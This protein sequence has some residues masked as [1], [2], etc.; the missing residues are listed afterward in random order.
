VPSKVDSYGPG[1]GGADDNQPF[2]ECLSLE[3]A[4][5]RTPHLTLLMFAQ[6][7]EL[8]EISLAP[9][10]KEIPGRAFL[11]CVKLAK[12]NPDERRDINLP[13]GLET[14]RI[15]AFGITA[16]GGE[17]ELPPGLRTFESFVFQP[18]LNPFY[19]CPI[20]R[21]IVPRSLVLNPGAFE[22]LDFIESFDL[23]GT[24]D[25]LKVSP[26]GK[27][28]IQGETVQWTARTL[29]DITIPA[30]VRDYTILAGKTSLTGLVFEE[31]P[32]R[33]SIPANSFKD[34]ANLVRVTLSSGIQIM[35]S[36]AFDDCAAL[37]ELTIANAAT[38]TYPMDRTVFRN[39][40]ALT[41][42]RVPQALVDTYKAHQKWKVTRP[43]VGGAPSLNDL[44]VGA[45][46]R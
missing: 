3:Y 2:V 5:I 25:I 28:L 21:L 23:N 19:M 13:Q 11:Q 35:N 8:K 42:I 1:P 9:E 30:G 44:V 34:C 24:G 18:A 29:G 26:E 45:D 10:T 6:C 38:V 17:L 20:T 41:S 33:T 37:E 27:L 4:D 40:A 31:D 15:D 12:I 7:G 39:C 16:L 14:I 43:G 32:G 22:G 36:N 46:S